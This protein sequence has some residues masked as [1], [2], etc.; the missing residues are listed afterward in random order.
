MDILNPPKNYIDYRC[1]VHRLSGSELT[2]AQEKFYRKK[3]EVKAEVCQFFNWLEDK[4]H[5]KALPIEQIEIRESDGKKYGNVARLMIYDIEYFIE[6]GKI[7]QRKIYMAD[8]GQLSQ[9]IHTQK[10]IRDGKFM[11]SGER[12]IGEEG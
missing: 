10:P 12:E 8:Q 6:G 7:K 3:S 5:S 9:N 1:Y 4:R 2:S 11:A